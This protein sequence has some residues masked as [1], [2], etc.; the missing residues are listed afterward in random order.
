MRVEKSFLKWPGGKGRII[1][2][3]LPHFKTDCEFIE[4]FA[5]AGNVFINV[6]AKSYVLADSNHDLINVYCWLKDDLA[7][8]YNTT[9]TL[10]D[11][12]NDFYDI[13]NQ[14][15]QPKYRQSVKLAAQFIWLNRH[16]FNGICRYNKS[17]KFNVPQGRHKKIY[18]PGAELINF[19]NKL[20]DSNVSLSACDF[21]STIALAKSGSVIYCDPPYLSKHKDS[22]V[23]Y[24]ANGF[25][26]SQTQ[27]LANSLY[28]AVSRGA[29][30]VISNCD[31][32][33]IR[34][35]FHRFKLHS[36]DAPRTIAANGDRKLAK[37]IIGIL[38]PDMI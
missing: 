14:F 34:E 26:Y 36:I 37:E 24:T 30:A 38:T 7:T 1:E 16:C 31:N 29:T 22:F 11:N 25:G 32:S 35:L 5:G 2:M 12:E 19:S 17:G 23:G 10:F 4:P 6:K 33:A 8:L 28:D 15:N 13:R 20:L 27:V 3:L 18:F 9:K 21:T